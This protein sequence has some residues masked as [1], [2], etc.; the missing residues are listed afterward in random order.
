MFLFALLIVFSSSFLLCF[1][2]STVSDNNLYYIKNKG[3][4]KYLTVTSSGNVVQKS[5]NNLETQR[6]FIRASNTYSNYYTI[7]PDSNSSKRL[8][9]Y[10][11]TD[12]NFQNIQ[13]YD[14]NLA[15]LSAQSFKF[16]LCSN[17]SY[18]IMPKLST[19][20][21]LDVTNASNS[22]DANIQLYQKRV[23]GTDPLS[24]YQEWYLIKATK[25]LLS[26]DLVD[27][28]K[29]LDYNVSN[30][31]FG[32]EAN[33]AKLQWNSYKS[34][35]VRKDTILTACDVRITD[36]SNIGAAVGLTTSDGYIKI[37]KSIVQNYSSDQKINVLTHEM[38]HA[39]GM[40][41]LNKSNNV[42]YYAVNS[43]T[44]IDQNNKDS[45]D[46]AYARY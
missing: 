10:N 40:G 16:I 14:E 5:L 4:N 25:S 31:S 15:Y 42:L 18:Q 7:T 35:I 1:S 44:V 30:S 8:D 33:A 28:G 17:T 21:V 12:A 36:A 37:N 27:T 32:E 22:N 24:A 41:H 39:L 6:F 26:F 38:G 45:Y 9:V 19:T 13:V 43:T 29:H 2:A 20:R 11:A 46:L 34:G 3:S 23:D